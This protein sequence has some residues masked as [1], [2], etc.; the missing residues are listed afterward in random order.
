[1]AAFYKTTAEEVKNLSL[2]YL[3]IDKEKSEIF[4]KKLLRNNKIVCGISWKST[5]KN[6]GLKRSIPLIELLPILS[7][8]NISFV[9]LQYGD[10]QEEIKEISHKYEIEIAGI[11]EIDNTND[12]EGLVTII[13]ACDLV[14]SV[15]NTTVHLAGA[16]GTKCYQLLP[17][18]LNHGSWYWS[19][20]GQSIW[21]KSVF[22]LIQRKQ[23]DWAS[24]IESVI[25]II[26]KNY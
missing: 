23:N 18:Q 6:S 4:R 22:N 11:N 25:E 14:I 3:V 9:N 5:N 21:Y 24:V 8:P 1:L 16:V 20:A 10:T 2:P 19:E 26:K 12:I 17:H 15:A 13:K 7:L